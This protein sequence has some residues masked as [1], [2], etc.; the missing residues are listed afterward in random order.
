[1]LSHGQSCLCQVR[2]ASHLRGRRSWLPAV[3]AASPLREFSAQAH[4]PQAL[5]MT[6]SL[7][8]LNL[9]LLAARAWRPPPRSRLRRDALVWQR[10]SWRLQAC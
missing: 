10:Y 2:L 5:R 6:L 9:S 4:P 1:M 8:T 7:L 3:P